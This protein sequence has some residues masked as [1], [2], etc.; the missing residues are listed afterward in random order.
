MCG[1]LKRP[2]WCTGRCKR[3]SGL[4]HSRCSS[5]QAQ[6]AG[7]P[8]SRAQ[9]LSQHSHPLLPSQTLQ[10]ERLWGLPPSAPP[11]CATPG[12]TSGCVLCTGRTSAQPPSVQRP[13]VPA[14]PSMQ[15]R[16]PAA[17][18]LG[19]GQDQATLLSSSRPGLLGRTA[20]AWQTAL[21]HGGGR[22]RGP[23]APRRQQRPGRAATERLGAARRHRRGEPGQAPLDRR[24][25]LPGPAASRGLPWLARRPFLFLRTR[26]VNVVSRLW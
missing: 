26:R 7:K 22:K 2:K 1:L 20:A 10:G 12:L 19:P 5:N 14:E 6:Y 3:R 24:R 25:R 23:R 17:F 16:Q 18:R 13:V 8:A 15:A 11:A 9:V 4:Q 21:Q